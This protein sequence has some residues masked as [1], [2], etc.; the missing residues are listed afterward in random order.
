MTTMPKITIEPT[1]ENFDVPVN[2]TKVPTRIWFGFTDSGIRIE[3]YVVS[4]V[5]YD[6]GDQG[7]HEWAVSAGLVR[8]RDK[9]D[10][11]VD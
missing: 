7:L 3:A 9:Y 11:K 4:I 8:S 6:D 10:I 2:G 1:D 5:P